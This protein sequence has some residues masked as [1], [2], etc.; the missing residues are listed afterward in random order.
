MI[1]P[2]AVVLNRLTKE[3]TTVEQVVAINA[4]A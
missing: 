1:V 4:L 2:N 3:K